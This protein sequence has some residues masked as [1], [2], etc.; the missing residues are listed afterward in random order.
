M[1]LG[2]MR[3]LGRS[4]HLPPGA[5]ILQP[6]SLLWQRMMLWRSS[7]LLPHLP[8]PP[9]PTMERS[10]PELREV[11]KAMVMQAG[12]IEHVSKVDA[13]YRSLLAVQRSMAGMPIQE[14]ETPEAH[15]PVLE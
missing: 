5:R 1:L 15:P 14:H 11:A 10:D 7:R 3:P 6:Q 13:A 12:S 9:T 2:T 8:M 4:K